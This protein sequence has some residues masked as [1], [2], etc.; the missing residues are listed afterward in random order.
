[1]LRSDRW[2][3]VI[4]LFAGVF[5]FTSINRLWPL[6]DADVLR[7]AKDLVPQVHDPLT[8]QGIDLTHYSVA[9]RLRVDDPALAYI[10]RNC[11]RER[12]QDF[13]RAS[14]PLFFY[15]LTAKCAGDP[16]AITI[17]V[18]PD[19]H[20][21]AWDRQVEDDAPGASLTATA[22]QSVARSAARPLDLDLSDWTLTEQSQRDYPHRR[23]HRCVFEHVLMTA[24]ELRERL[25][26]TVAGDRIA[27]AWHTVV[28]PAAATRANRAT[29]G[30]MHSS[31]TFG[32]ALLTV[33][34]VAAAALFLRRLG[35]AGA[36]TT[37]GWTLARVRIAP[38]AW[39]IAITATLLLI[40]D[41]SQ[42]A[43]LFELWDPLVPRAVAMAKDLITWLMDDLD[44]ILPLFAFIAA[45]DALDRDTK[46]GQS[47]DR[48]G[49]L[50]ALARGDWRDVRVGAASARGFCIG[51]ICGAVL[52][53]GA[54][55][56]MHLPGT[57]IE[58]QP[59]GFFFYPLNTVAPFLT[60]VC[61]F[62]QTALI[63]ECGYRFFMGAWIARITGST[64]AG[65]VIPS[66]VFGL[67]HSSYDFLPPADPWWAR[68]LIM[69]CVGSVWAWAFFRYGLL[70]VLLSHLS[71]DFFIFTWPRVGSGRLSEIIPAVILV[72]L[73][74]VPAVVCWRLRARTAAT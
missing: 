14:E 45:G 73:P 46:H 5:F 54:L 12:A 16:D 51:L 17:L 68:P 71:C 61:F 33:A 59:R 1:M 42:Q 22:A 66:L 57:R 19:G 70:T 60:T 28:V 3:V 31:Q 15:K 38:A 9:S 47:A 65:I 49:A 35:S 6:V 58:L 64:L 24:P 74:L 2:L 21:L 23:D 63:E 50:W 11:S 8:L 18:H 34:T 72:L 29:D 55:V 48:A 62:T 36:A 13:I 53:V 44:F 26:I 56:A 20:L 40:V 7:G 69:A 25:E 32:F 41:L 37:N 4:A 39:A 43:V 30:L 67:T 27:K 10:E 52:A